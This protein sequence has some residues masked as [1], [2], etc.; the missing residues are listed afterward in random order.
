MVDQNIIDR[1]E[2]KDLGYNLLNRVGGGLL[3]TIGGICYSAYSDNQVADRFLEIGSLPFLIEG[4]SSLLTGKCL[5]LSS[6]LTR[7]HPKYENS[8]MENRI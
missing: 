3:L 6:R 4:V 5:P 8:E 2:G 7:S 1:W